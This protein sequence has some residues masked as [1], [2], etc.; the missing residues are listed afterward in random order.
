MYTSY[1]GFSEKPFNVTP[2]PHF[3]YANR[4]YDEACATL[5]YG[6]RERKGFL[7][8]TGEV[9]TGKTTILRRLMEDLESSV[10]FVFFY[11]THL[12]FEE[13]LTFICDELGL[14]VKGGGQLGKIQTL[15]E[16]LLEQLRK[17]STVVLFI[18]EAQNLREE[19]FEGLRLLSNL[20]TPREKLLQIVLAGQPELDVKLDQTALRQLKQRI[21]SHSRLGSLAEEEVAAFINYRL[22]AVGCHRSDLL[23]P[24]VVREVARYSR[25]IPRLVNII[26]DNAL[27]IA[28]ADSKTKV[29]ADIIKEVAH[30]L[31]LEAEIRWPSSPPLSRLLS[32]RQGF[33]NGDSQTVHFGSTIESLN[34]GVTQTTNL[35]PR[36][37]PSPSTI[38]SLN[39]AV[40][41]PREAKNGS[42]SSEKMTSAAQR[43]TDSSAP[44]DK[45]PTSSTKRAIESV[46]QSFWGTLTNALTEAMGPMAPLIIREHL[47]ALRNSSLTMSE[48]SVER[49]IE[50]VSSEILDDLLKIAFKEKMSSVVGTLNRANG[51]SVIEGT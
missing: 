29:S 42:T 34:S 2:N 32:N 41:S 28:Y 9:G 51:D 38:D 4:A 49:L 14:T 10:R 23:P 44:R 19:V 22:K 48:G 12:N 18:D 30:D 7:V 17:G 36:T 27:L 50:L 15:N 1:F 26:C 24:N 33:E 6:I 40:I 47:T 16:F 20:E 21:F 39:T 11:N 5:L 3:F 13:I 45:V 43:A 35:E 8:L 31:R 46:P 25:G 37:V